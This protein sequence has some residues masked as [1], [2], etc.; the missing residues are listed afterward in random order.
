[1]RITYLKAWYGWTIVQMAFCGDHWLCNECEW[2]VPG[3][4]GMNDGKAETTKV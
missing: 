1:M 4:E 3:T 2:I